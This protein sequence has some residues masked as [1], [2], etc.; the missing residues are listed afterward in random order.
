MDLITKRLVIKL[1]I[2]T[3]CATTFFIVKANSLNILNEPVGV[4]IVMEESL[5]RVA[6]NS[7]TDNVFG[8]TLV[9]LATNQKYILAGCNYNKCVFNLIFL[10]K[11]KYN[12]RLR[13][14]HNTIITTIKI[15]K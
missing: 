7:T 3:L 14:T 12:V 4:S 5:L 2:I 1:L 10:P 11:G 15:M 9:N 6:T 13:T 8:I